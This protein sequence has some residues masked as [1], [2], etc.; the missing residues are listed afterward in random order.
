MSR[1]APGHL[2]ST[3]RRPLWRAGWW[4]LPGNPEF[5][6]I[7]TKGHRYHVTDSLH[8]D[9]ITD[10]L[11]EVHDQRGFAGTV[12]FEYAGWW[13]QEPSADPLSIFQHL[14]LTFVGLWPFSQVPKRHY[15]LLLYDPHDI[16]KC[17]LFHIHIFHILYWLF[18]MLLSRMLSWMVLITR[19]SMSCEKYQFVNK[20][21]DRN[22]KLVTNICMRALH[23]SPKYP[24]TT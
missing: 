7:N 13:T 9:T 2:A 1:V 17:N 5:S 11:S 4:C 22:L 18:R 10:F 3:I 15:A 19:D 6:L 23:V 12:Y 20:F 24:V 14:P 16:F 8:V 21:T